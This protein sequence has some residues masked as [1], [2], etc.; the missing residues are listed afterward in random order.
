MVLFSIHVISWL[1]CFIYRGISVDY[2][3][4]F[5]NL[6]C[7]HS[8][9]FLSVEAP[10]PWMLPQSW[11]GKIYNYPTSVP[12]FFLLLLSA[13]AFF[14][15]NHPINYQALTVGAANVKIFFIWC[16]LSQFVVVILK[17]HEKEQFPELWKPCIYLNR[18]GVVAGAA[19]QT[20]FLFL[21]L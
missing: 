1:Y 6:S 10:Q 11:N 7:I 3:Q 18:P 12:Y 5:E 19:L 2:S 17:Y 8:G 16:N 9:A 20:A 4:T 13:I 21:F 15:L 14:L